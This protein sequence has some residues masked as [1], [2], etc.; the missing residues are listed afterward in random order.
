M[1]YMPEILTGLF[2]TAT[3]AAIGYMDGHVPTQHGAVIVAAPFG[4]GAGLWTAC[5][6]TWFRGPAS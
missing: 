2:V 1:R 6:R 5:V 3:L 4:I